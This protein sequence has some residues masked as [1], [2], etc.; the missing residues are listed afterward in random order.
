[1]SY[2]GEHFWVSKT[3]LILVGAPGRARGAFMEVGGPGGLWAESWA[4][5]ESAGDR[6]ENGKSQARFEHTPPELMG[7]VTL[8]CHSLN[9]REMEHQSRTLL[10][11]VVQ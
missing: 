9:N 1:M 11:K 2:F 3:S 5:G 8:E 10:L 6:S 4:G 7:P